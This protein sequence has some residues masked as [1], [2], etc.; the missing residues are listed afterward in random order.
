LVSVTELAGLQPGLTDRDLDMAKDI[1]DA[2]ARVAAAL[3][4]RGLKVPKK[5]SESVGV[6]FAPI[7]H[8]PAL[9][10]QGGRLVRAF[11]ASDQDAVNEFSPFLD[12]LSAVIDLYAKQVIR[13]DDQAGAPRRAVPHDIFDRKL[14][15]PAPAGT[16]REP[17]PREARRNFSVERNVIRWRN[18]QLRYAFNLREGL[19]LHQIGFDDQG[20]R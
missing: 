15:G 17:R 19:V 12:G 10:Q 18:W 16:A 4:G 5:V 9:A 11:F 8:E 14:R 1:L 20:R 2:D 7:G 6:Q 3:V 13:R